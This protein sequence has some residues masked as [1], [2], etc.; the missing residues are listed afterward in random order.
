MSQQK[1]KHDEERRRVRQ[2]HAS[3]LNVNHLDNNLCESR[4]TCELF[5][6]GTARPGVGAKQVSSTGTQDGD[7]RTAARGRREST[8]FCHSFIPVHEDTCKCMLL[9]QTI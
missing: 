6:D 8:E 3:A 1:R 2:Q 7:T 5:A 9:S 4:L